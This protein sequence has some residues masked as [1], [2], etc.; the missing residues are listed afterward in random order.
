MASWGHGNWTKLGASEPRCW[1]STRW[2]GLGTLKAHSHQVRACS[3]TK[4]DLL[5]MQGGRPLQNHECHSM[6]ARREATHLLQGSDFRWRTQSRSEGNGISLGLLLLL[7]Q[8]W[9]KQE[10]TGTGCHH[11]ARAVRQLHRWEQQ[12]GHGALLVRKG[13]IAAIFSPAGPRETQHFLFLLQ[14][15]LSVFPGG[16]T[17]GLLSFLF[18]PGADF[19]KAQLGF[20]SFRAL[21]ST[22][23]VDYWAAGCTARGPCILELVS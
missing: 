20:Y 9:G 8:P 11:G 16:F 4:L 22:I 23:G 18:S 13:V 14:L 21:R 15:D 1:L 5:T 19:H 10:W 2:Q 3:L 7:R 6:I 17:A 12:S